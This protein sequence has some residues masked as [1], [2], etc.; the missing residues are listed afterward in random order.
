[1]AVDLADLAEEKFPPKFT[2]ESKQLGQLGFRAVYG[3]DS[4]YLTHRTSTGSDEEFIGKL[5]V[6]MGWTMDGPAKLTDGQRSALVRA[7]MEAFCDALVQ[8][9]TSIFGESPRM[10][11]RTG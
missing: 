8:S 7:D 9:E 3:I 5:M 1:M 6:A 4:P 10:R 11:A 2:I